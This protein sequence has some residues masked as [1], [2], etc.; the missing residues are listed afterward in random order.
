MTFQ[1]FLEYL[2]EVIEQRTVERRTKAQIEVVTPTVSMLCIDYD[3]N[4]KC[5]WSR[6]LKK[7]GV[8]M[9]IM[10]ITRPDVGYDREEWEYI[11]RKCIDIIRAMRR[12]RETR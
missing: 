10:R 8:L 1:G 4:L 7:G 11:G 9:T 3:I 2:G 12:E 5:I 6:N